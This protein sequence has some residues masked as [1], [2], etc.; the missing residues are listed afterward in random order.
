MA[1]IVKAKAK[2]DIDDFILAEL[3]SLWVSPISLNKPV[4]ML[5]NH[6]SDNSRKIA[7]YLTT[8]RRA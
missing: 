5:I 4:S 8:L 1:D 7:T 3:N 6:Y 2:K